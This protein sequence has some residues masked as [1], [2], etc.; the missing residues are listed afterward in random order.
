M[1]KISIDPAEKFTRGDLADLCDATVEAIADGIGFGWVRPP[2]RQRLEAYWK[3]VLVVPQRDLF[4]GRLDGTVAGSVQLVK[5]PPNFEAGT[6][7]AAIDTHFVAP[8]ARGHGLAK[9]LLEAAEAAALDQGFSVMRLDV[10]ATQDRA[11]ALY[12]SS[13]YKRWGTLDKYHMVDGQMIT[14]YFYVKDLAR[15]S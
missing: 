3:G 12:E 9:K 4:L 10:R 8:W 11:I 7:G 15:A 14:G 2:A 13:G 6:F 5:P 1:P